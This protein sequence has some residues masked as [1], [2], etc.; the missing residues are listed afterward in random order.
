MDLASARS[1]YGVAFL[2]ESVK[3]TLLHDVS[4]N[5]SEFQVDGKEDETLNIPRW[6]AALLESDGHA[7]IDDTDMVVELKQATVKENVQGT[8]SLPRLS[9]TSTSGWPTTLGA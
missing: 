4:V 5:V 7:S 6:I 9:P 2:M 3:I 8:L 1:L